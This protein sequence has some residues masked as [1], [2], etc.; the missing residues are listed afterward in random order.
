MSEIGTDCSSLFAYL[1]SRLIF[2]HMK[3]L[4]EIHNALRVGRARR[5]N[6]ATLARDRNVWKETLITPI[7]IN[8]RQM[9]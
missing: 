1:L 2:I 6:W 4:D 5:N 7:G 8:G 3:V 9:I